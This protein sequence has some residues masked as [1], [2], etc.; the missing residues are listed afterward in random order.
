MKVITHRLLSSKLT[1]LWI[2]IE[3]L[4][5]KNNIF[6]D[7]LSAKMLPLWLVPILKFLLYDW[8]KRGLA[9]KLRCHR[10]LVLCNW[11]AILS[12]HCN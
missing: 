7:H 10:G 4:R 12:I 3:V 1:I 6:M 2:F 8:T 11:V 9:I 5:L